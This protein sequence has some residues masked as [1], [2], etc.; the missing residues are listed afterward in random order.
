MISAFLNC[1]SDACS[2]QKGADMRKFNKAKRTVGTIDNNKPTRDSV[3]TRRSFLAAGLAMPLV[4]PRHVLGGAGHQAPSDTL[5]IAAVGIGGMG[6]IY[7]GECRNERIVALC[8][9]DHYRSANVFKQY[10]DAAR[11]HDFRKMFDK[12]AKNFDALIIGTPDHTHAILLMAAIKL[13]KHIYCAKPITHSIGEARKIR[14]ELGKAKHLV[15]K[16]SVQSSATDHARNTTELLKSGV[17]GG[18][19][20]LHIWC[21]HPAYPC[22]LVRPAESQTS[23]PG[24]DWDMWI[25]PAPYRPYHSAYHP[26]NWRPWWDFG[27]GTVGDMACHTMHVYF[28]ELQLGA[29]KM[30]YGYGST[31][32][33]GFFQFVSTPECQSHA[34]MVTWE[35]DARGQLPPINVHWYDGGMKP[36]RPAELDHKLRLPSSG[37][38]FVGE[39][40]KLITGYG[41]GNPFGRSNRGLQG[42]LLLPE[43]KFRDFE[44]PPKTMRRCNSHYTEWTQACKTGGRTVCPVEFG[45]EMT[46]LALLGTLALR[47]RRPLE[48]NAKEARITNSKEA[49]DL[50]D[51]PYRA[52]WTL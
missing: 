52:G 43:K 26:S 50:V 46:E 35:F 18:V 44:Q 3:L 12:E 36:N 9:L 48:W 6:Q 11:Y 14:A 37:L 8:D 4:I 13:N 33:K 29:P 23:P 38:L 45:C 28:K 42:G 2:A 32:H 24:M 1:P 21:D 7:L 51:P 30:V 22:S 17:I 16:S 34:N 19:R 20:E 5:R 31:K 27:T 15:T 49:N 41:G 10:P 47:T 39:K 25:G 40:G